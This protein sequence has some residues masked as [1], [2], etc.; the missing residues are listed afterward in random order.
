M[1]T[2]QQAVEKILTEIGKTSDAVRRQVDQKVREI[3]LDLLHENEGR[4]QGL[5]KTVSITLAASTQHY[6]LPSDFN[7]ASKNFREVDSDGDFVGR[8]D[9]IDEN[10]FWD[11]KEDEN[12]TGSKYATIRTGN[13]N[14]EGVG[15]Y[16][17]W[18][19]A[20]SSITYWEFPYY[21]IA[22]ENDTH[23]I[24]NETILL[25]GVR[26]RLPAY[27]EDAQMYAGMYFQQK[28]KVVEHVQA[29]STT[30]SMRPN[31]QQRHTNR[32]MH[33]IGRG[34]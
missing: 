10:Y 17:W 25:D 18:E 2:R 16:L 7:T 14:S 23:I 5:K 4:F 9:I 26:A 21:R 28:P 32:L 20:Y 1:L 22:T 11:R 8:R 29:R 19:S 31:A 30:M 15:F 13:F 12:D 27:Y 6:K 33:K 3:T 34:R 24:K